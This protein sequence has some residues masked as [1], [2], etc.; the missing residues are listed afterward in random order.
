MLRDLKGNVCVDT[1]DG[2][3]DWQEACFKHQKV[4]SDNVS[5]SFAGGS[6]AD[7]TEYLRH[8]WEEGIKAS[9]PIAESALETIDRELPHDSFESEWLLTGSEVD[10]GRYL[11][12]VPEC[13]IE[14]RPVKVSRVGRVVTL[15]VSVA[16]SAAVSESSIIKRG[17]AIVGLAMA[18]EEAQHACEIWLDWSNSPMG[19]DQSSVMTIRTPVKLAHDSIDPAMLAYLLGHPTVLRRMMFAAGHELP[20][21]IRSHYG[22]GTYYGMPHDPRP[23]LYPDGAIILPCLKSSRDVPE[24]DTFIREHLVKIGLLGSSDAE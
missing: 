24:P 11:Q 9:L 12:G 4:A 5:D 19:A 15:V 23:E 22:I 17:A 18:L 13:M 16:I 1:Y 20:A 7:V 6:W 8:G 21:S 14:Y 2:I 3:A 10:V